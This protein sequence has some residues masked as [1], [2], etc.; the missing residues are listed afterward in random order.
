M[1]WLSRP[2]DILKDSFVELGSLLLK[3]TNYYYLLLSSNV[4][5][6]SYVHITV[7]KGNI[8]ISIT[9]YFHCYKSAY[10]VVRITFTTNSQTKISVRFT[11]DVTG[12]EKSHLG[13]TIINL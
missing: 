1:S 12:F 13:C 11:S 9:Y 3:V 4:I 5:Y 10:L 8:V 7:Y 2:V 6:Y